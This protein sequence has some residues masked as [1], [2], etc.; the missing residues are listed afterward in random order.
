MTKDEQEKQIAK[1][2][3]NKTKYIQ[4]MARKRVGHKPVRPDHIPQHAKKH[5]VLH[6]A[7]GSGKTIPQ[8]VPCLF[9]EGEQPE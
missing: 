1:Q 8:I 4:D 5:T 9:S 7:T 2:K 6:I 3:E